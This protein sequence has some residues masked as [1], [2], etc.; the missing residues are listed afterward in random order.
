MRL[1]LK[2]RFLCAIALVAFVSG[3]ALHSPATA[4][5]QSDSDAVLKSVE[6]KFEQISEER[7]PP[8]TRVTITERELNVYLRHNQTNLA[9]KGVRDAFVNLATMR[10]EGSAIINFLKLRQAAN[11]ERPNWLMR[12]MLNGE[13]PVEVQ[14]RL[15]SRNGRATVEIQKVS[16]SGVEISGDTLDVLINRFVKPW[17]PD[18]QVNEPFELGYNIERLEVR[19][20]AVDIY[21]GN[22]QSATKSGHGQAAGGR[23][24]ATN[25]R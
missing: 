9:G 7:L 3:W 15:F 23:A 22:P 5:A 4:V 10:V 13:R 16:I 1:L 25:R 14:T 18:A 20:K 21:I 2:A 6:R 17:Y 12:Q 8:G 24:V 19:Q 11:A